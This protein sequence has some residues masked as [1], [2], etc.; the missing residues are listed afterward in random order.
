[1][2]GLVLGGA[3]RLFGFAFR[4]LLPPVTLQCPSMIRNFRHKGLGQFF[5][6]G[7]TRGINAQHAAKLRRLLFALSTAET[8]D[9]MNAPSYRLHQL[10]GEREGQWAVSVSGNWR[11][12]FEFE[13]GDVVN[14]DLVD[15]H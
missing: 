4:L 14:V 2:W 8:P 10:R 9:N 7:T 3:P 15:Y 12:V 13:D 1:M 5:Q 6:M 11:L